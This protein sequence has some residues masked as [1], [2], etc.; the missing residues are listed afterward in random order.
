MLFILN[1]TRI[2]LASILLIGV[3]AAAVCRLSLAWLSQHPDQVSTWLSEHSQT[4]VQIGQLQVDWSQGLPRLQA[5]NLLLGD[6][7]HTLSIERA[8]LF[9]STQGLTAELTHPSGQIRI[10]TN[11]ITTPDTFRITWPALTA[12]PIY[13]QYDQATSQFTLQATDLR[14]TSLHQL[15]TTLPAL[16]DQHPWVTSLQ[17]SGTLQRIHIDWSPDHFRTNLT[18][19]HATLDYPDLFRAPLNITHFTTE[20]QG[21]RTDADTW[22][23]SAD[24]IQ[25]NTPHFSS[26]SQLHLTLSPSHSP[27][28]DLHTQLEDSDLA[29]VRHYLPAHIM[30][31]KLVRWLDR[32]LRDGQIVQ[33]DLIL[34]GSLDRFPFHAQQDGNF[35]VITQIRNGT[36]AFHPDW[37]PLH[38]GQMQLTFERNQMLADLSASRLL[39]S[40]VQTRARIPRLSGNSLLQLNI[41]ADGPAQ[42]LLTVLQAPTLNPTIRQLATQ[43]QATGTAHSALQ[44]HLPL[45][46]RKNGTQVNGTIHL[47]ETD[48]QLPDVSFDQITGT[49]SVRDNQL[50]ADA[51]PAI[52]RGQPVSLTIRP[53]PEQTIIQLNKQFNAE[54]LAAWLPR[55]PT[56]LIRGTTPVQLSLALPREP[57]P[58]QLFQQL[59]L[60]SDLRGLEVRLPAPLGKTRHTASPLQINLSLG[61]NKQPH[62]VHYGDSGKGIFSHDWQQGAI[63]YAQPL[64]R[65]PAAG[66]HLTGNFSQ[67]DLAAWQALWQNIPSSADSPTPW[68]IDLSA[69]RLSYGML[70]TDRAQLQVTR[71]Q[72]Q[73]QSTLSSEQISGEIH[74]DATRHAV[75]GYLS[76]AHLRWPEAHKKRSD[77]KFPKSADWPELAILCDD[78]R[79]NQLALGKLMLRTQHSADTQTLQQ[80]SVQG[81]NLQLQLQGGWSQLDDETHVDGQFQFSDLG[82]WLTKW[83][84]ARQLHEATAQGNFKLHWAG[85]PE[86][87]SLTKL[88]G[89][90]AI[91][92]GPGRLTQVSPGITRILGLINVDTLKRR[93]K[94]DFDDLLKKGH[95]F[96]QIQGD[97]EFRA[98]QVHTRNLLINGPTSYVQLAGRIGLIEQDLEQLVYVIPK[99]D[100]TLLLAGALA[101]GPV[102]TLTSLLAQQLLRRQ[103]DSFTRFTY[104]VTGTWKQ[105]EITEISTDQATSETI[106]AL[107]EQIAKPHQPGVLERLRDAL[108][109]TDSNT[110]WTDEELLQLDE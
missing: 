11:R 57:S 73:I 33:S 37:P 50:Q 32:A 1:A 88:A 26:H 23:L 15:A 2:S 12:Q 31:P 29:A 100:G 78:L 97:F 46:A 43:I 4:L 90:A 53:E 77:V 91:Q 109:P 42:N 75:K 103:V 80:L 25:L 16:T 96:D 41:A 59:T 79:I 82:T 71:Q 30:S 104:Q 93:L 19:R 66:Y 45:R 47:T 7:P 92:L 87:Y 55:F 36:L 6:S 83:G 24:N 51:V 21:I 10:H 89:Q 63:S 74:Y 98:G 44:I 18:A 17:T 102:G 76:K 13:L 86:Q 107:Q 40:A 49:L 68:Q 14:L 48:L 95:S 60:D 28:L 85:R 105:P 35:S 20:L 39:H 3:L 110:G 94:L 54:T 101:G 81:D 70:H 56:H 106:Q 27:H 108:R 5:D 84:Y 52:L 65:L 72:Q 99:L 62:T 34:K 9:W 58:G 8:T 61:E 67:T 64:P 22:Q 38:I 69:D